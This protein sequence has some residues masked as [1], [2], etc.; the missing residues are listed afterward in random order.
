MTLVKYR[1][2][3]SMWGIAIDIEA[4]HK[5]IDKNN[6]VGDRCIHITNG[7][8]LVLHTKFLTEHISMIIKGLSLA[9]SELTDF[10][11]L[12]EVQNIEY[13]LSDFQLE[14]LAAAFYKWCIVRFDMKNTDELEYYFDSE[15]N[16]YVYN[17][18]ECTV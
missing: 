9:L 6:P 17:E 13:S 5:V 10:K 8:Y 7:H 18:L 14:G 2:I 3:K 12:V 16:R 1:A 15:N 11:V 4:T